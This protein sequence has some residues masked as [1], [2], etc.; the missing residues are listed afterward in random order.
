MGKLYGKNL[1][2]EGNENKI[3]LGNFNSSMDKMDRDC[4]NKIQRLY[5]CLSNYTLSKLIVGNGLE[6][7]W[8][9]ENPEFS[10]FNCYGRSSCI[11][12]TGSI[13][14]EKLLAKPK[15]IT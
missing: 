1:Y 9:R 8:R 7:L 3:I 2:C 4:G 11:R 5:K 10:E 13:L 15:L 12:Y 14:I 6:N